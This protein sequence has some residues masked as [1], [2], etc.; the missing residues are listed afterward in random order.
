LRG[1]FGYLLELKGR[2]MTQKQ[3]TN[4]MWVIIG[5]VF[6][7]AFIMQLFSGGQSS[8]SSS[9]YTSTGSTTTMSGTPERRYVEGRLRQE[10]YNQA[11]TQE[12]TNAILKF[13]QAQQNR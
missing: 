4:G 3:N 13:H 12:A 6:A 1:L 7:M 9:S 8:T 2:G 5:L 10:G 11:E